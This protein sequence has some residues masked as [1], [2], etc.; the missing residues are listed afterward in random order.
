MHC[1]KVLLLGG[2]YKNLTIV[3][4]K[5][6]NKLIRFLYD[7][8]DKTLILGINNRFVAESLCYQYCCCKYEYDH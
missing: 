2:S 1:L 6:Q 8:D 7:K 3:L 4:M 5:V